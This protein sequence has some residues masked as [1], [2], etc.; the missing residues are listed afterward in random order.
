M[1]VVGLLLL[2]LVGAICG[3]IAELIV[4]YRPGGLIVSIA[5]G[6][7][8]ALIGTWLAR[9]LHRP[10]L[11]SVGIEDWRI[12]ILWSVIGACLFLGLMLLL[13]GGRWGRPVY[14]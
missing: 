13:L 4:G 10:S 7:I 6:I 1:S 8:G 11:L 12:E 9:V 3:V 2:L 5:V 14:R